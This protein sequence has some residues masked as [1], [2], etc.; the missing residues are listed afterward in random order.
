MSGHAVSQHLE[1]RPVPPP[2]ELD[3]QIFTAR[4][5]MEEYGLNLSGTMAEDLDR[6]TVRKLDFILLPFLALLFLFNSLDRS[7]VSFCF[8]EQFATVTNVE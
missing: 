6:R 5:Q 3:E 7:N 4:S 2:D 1:L 8:R